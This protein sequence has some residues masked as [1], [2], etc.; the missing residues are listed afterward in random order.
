MQ[1]GHTHRPPR[2]RPARPAPDQKWDS[3]YPGGRAASP[4]RD[5]R[6]GA[7][8]ALGS[9]N[10]GWSRLT[11]GHRGPREAL[12]DG[13]GQGSAP[14]TSRRPETDLC[15]GTQTFL[16]KIEPCKREPHR[17]PPASPSSACE[18]VAAATGVPKRCTRGTRPRGPASQGP[19]P[20]TPGSAPTR[21]NTGS[22]CRS[23]DASPR[24]RRPSRSGRRVLCQPQGHQRRRDADDGHPAAGPSRG[25]GPAPGT[26]G[27]LC[28]QLPR[29]GPSFGEPPQPALLPQTS[30][31]GR[32]PPR[33]PSPARWGGSHCATPT[34][35]SGPV[36]EV[37]HLLLRRGQCSRRP[38]WS[39]WTWAVGVFPDSSPLF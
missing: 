1:L 11:A 30:R 38:R 4:G 12:R 10:E 6:G 7:S 18:A 14:R 27:V 36:T 32:R 21:P 22:T 16:S 15:P 17:M 3:V 33:A 39:W 35:A 28:L 5:A 9:K 20:R 31:R 13:P 24:P 8:G 26:W 19:S 23:P 29:R 34:P 25:P 2:L 37:A